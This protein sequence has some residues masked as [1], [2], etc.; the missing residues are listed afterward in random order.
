MPNKL[1]K[2]GKWGERLAEQYLLAQNYQI[3]K[4]NFRTREG[5]VD[6]IAEKNGVL[7]FVEVK[8]RKSQFF[9]EP[10]E[11][12]DEIKLHRLTKVALTYI[13]E[14][15]WHGSFRLDVIGITWKARDGPKLE[16]LKNVCL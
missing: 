2:L 16:H 13:R 3:L 6:L 8:T 4:V 5:E 10:L 7:I 1:Q 12:V 14:Y 15:N 9:G 11:A